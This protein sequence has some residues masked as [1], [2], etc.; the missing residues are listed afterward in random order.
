MNILNKLDKGYYFTAFW[1]KGIFFPKKKK[2]KKKVVLCGFGGEIQTQ[3]FN[4]EIIIQTQKYICIYLPNWVNKSFS[5]DFFEAL[6]CGGVRQTQT[7]QPCMKLCPPL[8][9]KYELFL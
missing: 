4:N 2:K 7:K 6:K 8:E 5:E 1:N 9:Y 3:I